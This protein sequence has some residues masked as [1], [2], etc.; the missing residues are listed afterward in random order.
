MG[1]YETRVDA[2]L[3]TIEDWHAPGFVRLLAALEAERSPLYVVGGA[4]R[5]YLLQREAPLTDLDLVMAGPVLSLA[6]R[7]ADRLGWAFFPLDAERDVARLVLQADDTAPLVCD[8]ASLRGHSLEADL[9][10]RDFTVNA[11]ALALNAA[12]PPQL[13]DV[14]NGVADLRARRIRTVSPESLRND[15][16]RLLRAVRLAAQLGFALEPAVR[17]QIQD[18]ASTIQQPSWERIRD[19]LWKTLAT[20]QPQTALAE[21]HQLRLLAYVLPE[22]AETIG[23]AQTFPHHADVYEHTLSVVA[24]AA[25]LRDWLTDPDEEGQL[26]PLLRRTLVP[27]QAELCDH[28]AQTLAAGRSRADWLVWHALFHD[29]GK[30]QTRSEEIGRGGQRRARFLGH[31]RVSAELAAERLTTLRFSRRE[32]TLAQAVAQAH[33]HPHHL[34]VSFQGRSISRRAAF[35]F[36]RDT[37]HSTIGDESGLDVLALALADY[38]AIYARRSPADWKAYLAHAGQLLAFVFRQKPHDQKP[39]VDGHRLMAELDLAPGRHIG[40][41]LARILEAQATGEVGSEEEAMALAAQ[42]LNEEIDSD[43]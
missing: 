42:V 25:L 30:P 32:V 27:W 10:D 12:G 36:F 13:V 31:E 11:L 9:L 39:L 21:L 35:R 29:T 15:P 1:R 3:A 17:A 20:A 18:L 2:R 41:L 22:V 7:V 5:D 28:F 40:R 4:L 8:V 26:D 33:M 37:A 43:A 16:I 19:E 23:V 38:Q 34:H 24:A 6:R 14:C